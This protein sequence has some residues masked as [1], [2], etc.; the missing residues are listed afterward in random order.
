MNTNGTYL[1]RQ[2][3]PN[4]F[5]GYENDV[6]GNVPFGQIISLPF[7]ENF[8]REGFSHFYIEDSSMPESNEITFS[9][10]YENGE[11]WVVAFALPV[12]SRTK[13]PDG[14]LM[15]DNWRYKVNK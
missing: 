3:R 13:A 4:Y 10:A 15:R 2:Y 7:F 6:Y 12:D 1:V 8:K 5:S 11:H 14:G 9:A